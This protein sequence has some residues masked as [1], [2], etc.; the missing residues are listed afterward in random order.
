MKT[1][2][3]VLL[4]VAFALALQTTLP[5]FPVAHRPALDFVLVAVVVTALV[6]GPVTGL[7]T[8]SVAGIA[9]DAL[10]GGVIGVSGF[11]KTVVGF[12]VGVIGRQFIVV[13]PVPRFLVFF[14][15][16]AVHAV[17]FLGLY[18][19]I[20]PRSMTVPYASLLGEAAANGVVG[21]LVFQ[22]YELLP[23]V[24]QRRRTR[25]RI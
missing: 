11:A 5:R 14:G 20:D 7:L 19:M 12:L 6:A 9:Q 16:T 3:A 13:Q 23:S 8:G 25:R 15:A 4:A 21:L 2:A 24:A 18:A 22:A 1:T 17:C 10:A